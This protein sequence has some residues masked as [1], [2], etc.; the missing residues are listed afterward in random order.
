MYLTVPKL[1]S[2]RHASA[3]SSS[4]CRRAISVTKTKVRARFAAAGLSA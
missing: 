3:F 1:G 2:G 4:W